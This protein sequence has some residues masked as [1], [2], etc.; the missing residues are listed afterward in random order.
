MDVRILS[1]SLPVVC[2]QTND[3]SY[4]AATWVLVTFLLLFYFTLIT[5]TYPYSHP[6]GVPIVLFIFFAFFPPLFF[7]FLLWLF[8]MALL[9]PLRIEQR[10][11]E[12][13]R[14]S[15]RR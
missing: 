5:M 9:F 14:S 6:R 15:S 2:A 11:I 3:D 10:A 13:Q 12:E 8:V 1:L 4:F 7:F